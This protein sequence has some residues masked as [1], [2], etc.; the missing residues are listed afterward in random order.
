MK[1]KITSVQTEFFYDVPLIFTAKDGVRCSYICDLVEE[2][3]GALRYICC[4]VSTKRLKDLRMGG[5]DLRSIFSEPEI[6]EFYECIVNNFQDSE[7]EISPLPYKELPPEFL[8]DS[9]FYLAQKTP[10][11]TKIVE[12]A[13]AANKPIFRLTLNPP[14]SK[15]GS[16]ILFRKTQFISPLRLIASL[17]MHTE[18][19]VKM[20]LCTQLHF[21]AKMHIN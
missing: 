7:L 17:S 4:P 1:R 20:L 14:E 15:D 18:E 13:K 12:V 19:H 6:R 11:D 8:P 16:Y 5:V 9:G 10:E 3:E 21:N 2:R